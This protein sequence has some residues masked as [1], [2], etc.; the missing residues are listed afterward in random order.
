MPSGLFQEFLNHRPPV[1]R[2]FKTTQ[3][4]AN[5]VLLRGEDPA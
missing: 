3:A 4:T 5:R 2:I 1:F